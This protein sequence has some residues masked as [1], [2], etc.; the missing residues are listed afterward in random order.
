MTSN[1]TPNLSLGQGS[2]VRTL[3][4]DTT[5]LIKST[6]LL[7]TALEAFGPGGSGGP[8]L[9]TEDDAQTVGSG[10]LLPGNPAEDLAHG[11]EE[12]AKRNGSGGF[13]SFLLTPVPL[14][15]SLYHSAA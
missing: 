10:V 12:L 1:Q 4:E 5:Q 3:T 11:N 8:A 13:L 14:S 2:S 15:I 7:S 9:T 6:P